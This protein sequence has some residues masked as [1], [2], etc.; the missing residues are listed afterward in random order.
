MPS[1]AAGASSTVSVARFP[2]GCDR[3]TLQAIFAPI[4]NIRQIR[5]TA[6][7]HAFIDFSDPSEAAKAARM[8]GEVIEM[9]QTRLIIELVNTN[10]AI[11][12]QTTASANPMMQNQLDMHQ[13]QREMRERQQ[14][15]RA[16]E[17]KNAA[18]ARIAEINARLTGSDG[19]DGRSR[20]DERGGRRS[21]SPDRYDRHRRRRSRSR[22]RD[23]YD[24]GQGTL[25]RSPDYR[26]AYPPQ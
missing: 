14:D 16:M 12:Y 18:A 1:P 22:S 21:P 19:R 10:S 20:R 11:N 2:P 5:Y 25:R 9:L 24:R 8:S 13:R 7:D 15:Q 17:A 6:P 3:V 26:R 4:G 23:R